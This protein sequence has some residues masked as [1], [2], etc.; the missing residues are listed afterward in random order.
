LKKTLIECRDRADGPTFLSAFRSFTGGRGIK[1]DQKLPPEDFRVR[2]TCLDHEINRSPGNEQ[3]LVIKFSDIRN[4]AESVVSKNGLYPFFS[5]RKF[6]YSIFFPPLIFISIYKK[7]MPMLA[8]R[9]A[10]TKV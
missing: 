7:E 4:E 6:F 1:K 5:S 9:A 3:G 2:A 10:V 8:G